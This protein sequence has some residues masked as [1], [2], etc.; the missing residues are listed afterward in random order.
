[1]KP[2]MEVWNGCYDAGWNGLIVPD[3]FA[4]P[5]KFSYRLVQR[6]V[7][8]GLEKGYWKPVDVIGDPFGGVALGGIV[9]GYA[10][11]NWIG[12]ELEPRF[13]ELGNRNLALH[14]PKWMVLGQTNMVKLV[15]GDSRRFAEI[16][17]GAGGVVTS[18][19]FS[20]SNQNYAEAGH[21]KKRLAERGEPKHGCGIMR[22]KSSMT[23]GY[24]EAA[25]QIG[26]LREGDLDAV[27]QNN[28]YGGGPGCI[29]NATGETYW[30]AMRLVYASMRDAMKPGAFAAVVVKSYVKKGKIVDLPSQTVQLLEHLGFKVFLRVR[31]MLTKTETHE[32]LFGKVTKKKERKSFFR[33][34]AE[35]KGSPAIDFEEVIFARR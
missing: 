14:G 15:Q 6:I 32:G 10:G 27:M 28:G 5:A 18:P 17:R 8:Y 12:V 29:G 20:E 2:S 16:V 33:R 19:P 22:G 3:A 35:S 30:S 26:R 24:G 1:M 21:C 4:H 34:L 23:E 11:L 13:V 9:C 25:G 7:A 31:A